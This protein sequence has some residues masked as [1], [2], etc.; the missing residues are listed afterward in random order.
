AVFCALCGLSLL[1]EM[2]L[3]AAEPRSSAPKVQSL[4]GRRRLKAID[5][6]GNLHHFGH[7]SNFR[8][9]VVVFLSTGCPI[10]NGY[11]PT[12]TQLHSVWQQKGFEFYGVI[13]GAEVTRAEALDHRKKFDIKFPVLFDA[14]GELRHELKATHTPQ[15]FVLG[16][17]LKLVYSGLID[18]RYV[19]LGRKRAQIDQHYLEDALTAASLRK[20]PKV[21]TTTPIGCRLEEEANAKD[22]AAP[23]TY[24]RD[25]APIV[26]AHCVAC[27]RPGEV[28]PFSLLTYEDVSRHALQISEVTASRQMPPWK[29]VPDFGHF[30]EERRLSDSEIALFK[31]WV[32]SG[33]AQGD[34]ADIPAPAK[35]TEGWQLGTPDLI[36]KVTEPLEISADGDT[37]QHCFVLPTGL[38]EN[39][40][41]AAVEFRPGNAQVVHHASFYLDGSGAAQKRDAADPKSGYLAEEGLGFMPV[42]SFRSWLPGS[43][44]ARLP[45]G[46]GTPMPR[47]TDLILQVHYQRT[48]RKETDQSTVGIYFAPKNTRQLVSELQVVNFELD[49]PAGSRHVHKATYTVPAD[50][51]LLD[52]APHMHMLGKEMKATAT[53]PDGRVEPLIYINDW[54]RNWQGQYAYTEP[55]RLPKGT[56]IDV[57][58]VFDNSASNPLNPYSPPKLVRWGEQAKSEMAICYFQFTCDRLPDFAMVNEHQKQYFVQKMEQ[59][60]MTVPVFGRP[61]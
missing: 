31:T 41:V 55:I 2:R 53:L 7:R 56:R 48:G 52:A 44:P 18:N 5:L 13:S 14:S 33:K 19:G 20:S 28:G 37:F 25:I 29:P 8:G 58:A 45:K 50:L 4:N 9:A 57:E 39:R 34:R 1:P 23:V 30:R 36:L 60:K 26:Q 35:F 61:K 38:K 21:E 46:M 24:A 47:G 40:L 32:E 49:I 42:G 59:A 43:T 6:D 17:D 16:R 15:V 10:S 22:G 54:D 27:H 11:L 3:A 51:T 12:L